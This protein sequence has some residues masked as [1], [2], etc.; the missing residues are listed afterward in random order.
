[1]KT[2]AELL[3]KLPTLFK[4]EICTRTIDDYK[5]IVDFFDDN[6]I[7]TVSTGFISEK[8]N[9]EPK[10]ISN[11]ITGLK[12]KGAVISNYGSRTNGKRGKYK[13]RKTKPNCPINR[14]KSLADLLMETE[15]SCGNEFTLQDKQKI[16]SI[17]HKV[18]E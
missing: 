1:M 4:W 18:L 2:K 12:A 5:S 3:A 6:L 14:E 7:Q 13:K 10:L 16:I 8:L 15:N 9:L 11:Y 17:L